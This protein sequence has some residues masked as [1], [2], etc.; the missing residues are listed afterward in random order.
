VAGF[1]EV[2]NMTNAI[3]T[4]FKLMCCASALL[5]G[6]CASTEE[7]Y[8]EYDAQSCKFVVEKNTGGTLMVRELYSYTLHKWQPVVFFD[9]D[10]STLTPDTIKRLKIALN[11][12]D[13]VSSSKL[14][15]QGFADRFGATSYNLKLARRRVTEVQR[16]L[17][18]NGVDKQRI[19]LRAMGE[20][21]DVRPS[22]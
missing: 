19:S 16:W 15:L 9:Y 21:P 22:G 17:V 13:D 12:L 8:A 6:A 3:K 2:I 10:S 18:E 4:F 5:L 11:V 1:R 7:L 20:G 14:A